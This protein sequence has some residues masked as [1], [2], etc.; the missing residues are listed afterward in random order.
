MLNYHIV[1]DNSTASSILKLMLQK[2]TVVKRHLEHF[3]SLNTLLCFL[4]HSK[5][6]NYCENLPY[7]FTKT[8]FSKGKPYFG[9]FVTILAY[10]TSLIS[11]G[12]LLK[13]FDA[14]V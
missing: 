12:C 10:F 1:D 4:L 9:K 8:D 3:F 13:L 11:D 5:R 7:M 14:T 2:M 6:W